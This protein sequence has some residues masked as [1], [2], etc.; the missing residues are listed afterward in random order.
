MKIDFERYN[1]FRR[2]DWRFERVLRM[3]DRHPS[4]GRST[5][6]DDEW[7]KGLRQFI[8]RYRSASEA[9]RERLCYENPG[10][11]FAWLIHERS[12][13]E[14]EI[15]FMIEARILANQSGRE[16]CIESDTI[17]EAIDWYE[18]LFFDVRT[19]LRAHDWVMKHV[20]VP[21]VTRAQ[22]NKHDEGVRFPRQPLSEPFYDSTL[23]FFG[24][25]GGP[26]LIDFMLAGFR[27]GV[28]ARSSEDVSAWLDQYTS[29]AAKRRSRADERNALGGG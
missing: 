8:L 20:L 19:R 23:K 18:H 9:K 22:E 28:I 27:R 15:A 16:I 24:Y 17:P 10:L 11:Y 6:R 1:P 7:V 25:F 29:A 13:D 3:V 26:V 4:P 2:P 12:E 5:K 14:P 21:S